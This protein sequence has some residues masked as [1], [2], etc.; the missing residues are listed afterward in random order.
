[1]NYDE[2]PAASASDFVEANNTNWSAIGDAT[3]SPNINAWQR[4]NL[5]VYPPNHVWWGPDNNGQADGEKGDAPDEQS[6]V[7][8]ILSVGASPLTLSFRH[9]FA[10]ENGGWDGG[11]V[12]LSTNGGASWTD[13]GA[14][15]YNGLTNAATSAPIGASHPAFVNRN[16]GW[17][18]FVNA[19]L[20]LGTTYAGRTSDPL[21]HRGRRDHGRPGLGH[22]RHQP[23]RHHGYAVRGPDRPSPGGLQPL[24]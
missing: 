5:A 22:R 13:I 12:E 17:P 3:T 11:V 19:A 1:V 2:Q 18:N 6:L 7:S 23:E 4:R 14:G 15:S 21:P 16:V 9:R 20:N 8:P 24:T 10:F